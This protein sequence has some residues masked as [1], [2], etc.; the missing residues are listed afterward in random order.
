MDRE[1]PRRLLASPFGLTELQSWLLFGIGFVFS[2][3]AMVDG[4]LF[5]DPV[6]GYTG[7]ERRW[8]AASKKFTDAKENLIESLRDIRDDAAEAMNT[9]ARD[10]TVRRSAFED[11][12]KARGRLSQRFVEHQ[13]Q[14][15]RACN[16]LLKGTEKQTTVPVQ[17]P[18]RFTSIGYTRWIGFRSMRPARTR[19]NA[20]TSIAQSSKSKISSKNR[21]RQS[22]ARLTKQCCP[23]ERST[24]FS[25]RPTVASRRRRRRRSEG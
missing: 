9:A 18:T 3:G 22:T 17:P 14:T 15:E 24:S 10:L 20:S 6:I 7:L 2:I 21:L 11:L 4:L 19:T 23:T 16:A 13:S 8:V 25:R 12:L 5:F 1:A